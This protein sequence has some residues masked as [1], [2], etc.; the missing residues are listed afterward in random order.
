MV[1]FSVFDILNCRWFNKNLWNP[2][3]KCVWNVSCETTLYLACFL[4]ICYS[5]LCVFLCFLHIV[6]RL[7][8]VGLNLVDHLPLQEEKISESDT[9]Q[10]SN[11]K[12]ERRLLHLSLHLHGEVLKHVVQLSDA[13][14]QLQDLIVP[15][16]DLIQ[17]L[18][19]SFSINQDLCTTAQI[20]ISCIIADTVA[21]WLD[22]T[23]LYTVS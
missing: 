4:L 5:L 2:T 16:L 7:F 3:L 21:L 23:Y 8:D 14:L 13:P 1:F 17:S 10:T 18:L 22:L 19:C 9:L 6:G 20:Y 12:P 15:R 11:K